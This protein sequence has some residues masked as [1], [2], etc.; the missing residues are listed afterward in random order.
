MEIRLT[1]I[2]VLLL[3]LLVAGYWWLGG[4]EAA[5]NA[6]LRG[7]VYRGIL[8]IIGAGCITVV[9][10][11]IGTMER[12]SLRWLYILLG[13]LLMTAAVTWTRA[14]HSGRSKNPQSAFRILHRYSSRH[15]RA[16][17]EAT[18]PAWPTC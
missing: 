5:V 13:L 3:S 17:L 9:E 16:A 14:V 2:R 10:H 7:M 4:F 8:F 11:E 1:S 15:S 6:D 18:H 12:T